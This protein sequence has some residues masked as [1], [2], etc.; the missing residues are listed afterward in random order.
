VLAWKNLFLANVARGRIVVSLM[1]NVAEVA[2]DLSASDTTR[3]T[4]STR[5]G[6]NH[7]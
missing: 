7:D 4:D 2:S 1:E 6:Q 3:A 5:L